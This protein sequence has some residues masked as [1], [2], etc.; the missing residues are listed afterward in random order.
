MKKW[1][2]RYYLS[3]GAFR[4]GCP[5]FTETIMGDRTTVINWA[6]NKLR[7]SQFKFFDFIEA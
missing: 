3:E 7:Y 2:I 1:I 4:T 5:S 6:Q